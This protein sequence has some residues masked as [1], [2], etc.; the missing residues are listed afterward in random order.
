MSGNVFPLTVEGLYPM[1]QSAW[2][3]QH[4]Y[5]LRLCNDKSWA[6]SEGAGF[7]SADEAT[8]YGRGQDLWLCLNLVPDP[9]LSLFSSHI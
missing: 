5:R 2:Y 8:S 6:N 1:L 4:T 9:A 3:E 7:T